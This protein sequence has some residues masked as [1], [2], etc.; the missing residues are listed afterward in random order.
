VTVSSVYLPDSSGLL[1]QHWAAISCNRPNTFEIDW[2]LYSNC[3]H[4]WL[5]LC[6]GFCLGL[7]ASSDAY[8]T[9]G[10][11]RALIPT[12]ATAR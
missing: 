10:I 9:Q 8:I 2:L 4:P 3:R 7:I 11:V 6:F 1:E 12:E 5:I